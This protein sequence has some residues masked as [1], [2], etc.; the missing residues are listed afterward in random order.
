MTTLEQAFKAFLEAQVPTAG[1]SYPIEIPQDAAM[2]AWSYT[3][4]DDEQV[5]SHKGGTGFYKARIQ[6]DLMAAEGGG[7]SDYENAKNLA[8]AMLA[9]LDGYQGP[10][11]DRQVDYCHATKSDDWADIHQLPIQR[12]DVRINYR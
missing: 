7:K 4:I 2:P 6:I 10:M 3:V 12:L 8:N 11:S 5:L 9:A 1:K